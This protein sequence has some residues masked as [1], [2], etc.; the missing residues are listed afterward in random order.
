[1]EGGRERED[2]MEGGREREDQMEGGQHQSAYHQHATVSPVDY[3]VPSN[4]TAVSNDSA[5]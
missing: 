2:Q 5:L 1:M 3:T 4:Q